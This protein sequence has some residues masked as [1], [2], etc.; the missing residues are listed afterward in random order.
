MLKQTNRGGGL[1]GQNRNKPSLLQKIGNAIRGYRAKLSHRRWCR[2]ITVGQDGRVCIPHVRFLLAHGCNINCEF[3]K[4]LNPFRS[5]ITPK[6]QLSDSFEKWSP[7]ILPKSIYLYGGEPLLNPHIEEIVVS[8]HHYWSQSHLEIWTNGVL[9]PRIPDHVLR[10]FGKYNVIVHI[11]QHFVTA[12]FQNVLKQEIPRLEQF[13]VQ[14]KVYDYCRQWRNDNPVD[15]HGVPAPCHSNPALAFRRCLSKRCTTVQG[16]YLYSCSTLANR[17]MAMQEGAI[18]PEWN[19]V[20]TH[21]PVSYENSPQEIVDYLHAG[22]MPECSICPETYEVVEARQ[23]SMEE[24]QQIKQ[25]IRQRLR[26]TA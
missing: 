16:D 21:K 17:I 24:V 10:I 13:S 12:E 4:F 8:A 26:K 2:K 1:N 14:H 5:G 6:E 23:L 19:R 11:S 18:G 20:T 7:K 15:E 22:P 25:H 3:C 9:L